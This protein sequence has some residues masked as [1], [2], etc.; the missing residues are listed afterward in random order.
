M[1][2]PTPAETLRAAATKLRDAH[3]QG[4]MT[5]T[6]AVAALV[7]ARLPIAAWLEAAAQRVTVAAP[8]WGF[9]A[10]PHALV[11][12]RELLGEDQPEA[13][14]DTGLRDQLARAMALRDGHP[15]WPVQYEDDEAAYYRRA[16]A[17]LAV[18]P[19]AA[20]QAA[21]LREAAASVESG[22]VEFNGETARAALVNGG[23]SALLAYALL[24]VG[25]RLRRLADEAQQPA[26]CGRSA[27]MR[28]PCSAGDH[29]CQGPVAEQEPTQLR[30]GLDDV[31]WGDDDTTTIMLSG[32]DGAPYWLELDAERTAALRDDLAGP[33]ATEAHRPLVEYIAEVLESDGM[34]MYLGTDPDRAVAEKR[35]AGVVRRHPEA[36]TRIVRKVT[37]YTAEPAG[38]VT[39]LA[40]GTN[41]G[42]ATL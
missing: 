18:L 23:E 1:P 2:T 10:E 3:L 12:A 24:A 14:P 35:C 9:D 13:V 20:D 28:T 15:E 32:P 25:A 29:C 37:T 27:A 7:R 22:D 8:G 36:Q 6:P 31:M 16:D 41:A 38:P 17:V 11:A 34:W 26:P 42:E 5:A 40:A 21:V 39:H 19:V 4:G 30:W 33:G